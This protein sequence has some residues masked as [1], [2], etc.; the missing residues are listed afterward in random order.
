MCHLMRDFECIMKHSHREKSVTII[1]TNLK[2]DSSGFETT[3]G[4]SGCG[5]MYVTLSVLQ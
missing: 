3:P 2:V 4:V 5:P 1:I